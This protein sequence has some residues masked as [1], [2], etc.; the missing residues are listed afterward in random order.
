NPATSASGFAAN[1][2]YSQY[3]NENYTYNNDY[4]LKYSKDFK[5][6]NSHLDLQAGY[7]YQYF[8]F[9][10][11]P[12]A[13]Y[14]AD[15]VT[16][17][18]AAPATFPGQYYIESPFGRLNFD[19]DGKYLLTATIRDDRSSRFGS[20]N[21]NGYFPS[22][23]LAWR[24]K[25]ESFF[26]S[27]DVLSDLKLR[28]GYGITGQQ[29][30]GSNYFPYLAVYEPSNTG[31]GYGFGTN[32][33]TTLRADAYN[34]NLKWES[35]ATTNVGLDYGFLNGRIN[36]SID[37]Y[38]RKT[39]DLLIFTP[40][41]DGTNLSN[42][43]TANIGN[44]VTKGLDFN[45]NVIAIASKDINWTMGYNVSYNTRK[46]T[47]ISLTKDPNL[48]IPTGAINGLGNTIQIYK[49]GVAPNAF[50]PFQQVY[51]ANGAPL[52]GVYVDRNGNG[53]TS[54]DNYVYKQPNPVVFMGF[55]SNFSYK[56]WDLAFTLRADL[57]N[58][59][60]NDVAA[61]NAAYINITYANFLSN[62]PTSV[63][64]T[65]FQKQQN[66][67]DY[68]IEN[69]SF[70]R[71]DNINLGYNFG[72]ITK[73]IKLRASFNVQNVFVVTKYTGLDPEVQGGIDNNIYPRP[74]IYSLGL[75]ASF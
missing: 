38:Y 43:I 24:L 41:P 20:S 8:H 21:R 26:K 69:G 50:Y 52:E 65:N 48:I 34:S 6:I 2:S 70:L 51:G 13:T 16:V 60:Y 45:I 27:V 35:T 63:L 44:L 53:I 59:V 64:K 73:V 57:G 49:A 19:V 46:V 47:N 54:D 58:Y 55:N 14:K 29:D 28:V 3:F 40:V 10:N 15:K 36:G 68:Y 62:L 11:E 39:K 32:Y 18:T 74:R 56:N 75:N 1:G 25:E 22:V 17:N 42:Y 37:Y 9:Y 33:T 5:S 12:E 71:M 23:A 7:S 61:S 4:Y 67:S 72:N 30:V 31:A 66:Y